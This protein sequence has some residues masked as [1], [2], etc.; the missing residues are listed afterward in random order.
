MPRDKPKQSGPDTEHGVVLIFLGA[1]GLIALTAT[2]IITARPADSVLVGA[3]T[4]LLLAGGG[5]T[6]QGFRRNGK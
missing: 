2:S 6:L 4:T 1:V 3:F 5:F